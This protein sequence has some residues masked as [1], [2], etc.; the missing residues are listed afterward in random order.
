MVHLHRPWRI[1]LS[2]TAEVRRF[3]T[4]RSYVA[5]AE[6]AVRRCGDAVVDMKYFT[7]EDRPPADVCELMFA[8]CDVYVGVIGF[9]YGSPI[10]DRPGLS[11]SELEFETATAAGL[12]RLVFLLDP[13]RTEG[14]RALFHDDT[15][16]GDRQE[17]FRRRLASSGLL[18]RTVASPA[19]LE[20][21]LVTALSRLHAEHTAAATAARASGA[22]IG[23]AGV[24]APG[25]GT[26]G[27][28]PP[29][30][31]APHRRWVDRPELSEPL[32]AA[33]RRAERGL[34]ALCGPGGFGKTTLAAWL[35]A[36]PDVR[37]R[38]GERVWWVT[39]GQ[40]CTGPELALTVNQLAHSVSG[41]PA[42][43]TDPAQA[44]Q[45]L[46]RAAAGAAGP[47]RPALLVVDDVWGPEQLAPFPTAAYGWTVLVTTRFPD[48]L[49]APTAEVAVDAL[50]D[51][52]AAELLS[53]GLGPDA[54]AHARTLLPALGGWPIV[55]SLVN[56]QL[57]GLLHRGLTVRAA[58]AELTSRPETPPLDHR[59]G[60]ALA[61]TL[62][63]LARR[64]TDWDRRIVELAIFPEDTAVPLGVIAR[65]WAATA[66]LRPSAARAVVAAAADL[67]LV[68]LEPGDEGEAL[69]LHD[70]IRS[71]LAGRG[72][73][74]AA[75]LHRT[76]LRAVRPRVAP[77]GGGLAAGGELGWWDLEWSESYLWSRLTYHLAAAEP[78]SAGPGECRELDAL[79]RDGRWLAARLVRSGPAG[80][81]VDLARSGSPTAR[82]LRR[83]LAAAAHLLGPLEPASA[84]PST[85]LSRLEGDELLAPIAAR[86][87]AGG[88][89]GGIGGLGGLG[90]AAGQASPA[91]RPG[92]GGELRPAW[93]LPD[94]VPALRRT[95]SGDGG[96]LY[97]LAVSPDGKWLAGAGEG[98]SVRIWADVETDETDGIDGIDG[99]DGLEGSGGDGLGGDGA[100][101]TAR[102]AAPG[103]LR[104]LA[105]APDGTWLAGAGD[106]G[107]I[108]LW[109]PADGTALVTMT[110]HTA[111]VRALATAPDG[112]WLAS[113]GDDTTIRLW[114]P[115]DGRALAILTGHTGAVR[116]LATAPDGSWLA[117]AGDDTTIRL[118]NPANGRA[119]AT[120]ENPA[121]ER[122]GRRAVHALV[123]APD[124]SWL[125]SAGDDGAVQLWPLP[126]P[127]PLNSELGT[128][129]GHEVLARSPGRVR[130]LAVAPDGSWLA[131]AGDD[132]TVRLWNTADGGPRAALGQGR[133]VYALAAAPDAGWVASAGGDG[134]LRRWDSAPGEAGGGLAAPTR[135]I[136]AA[137]DGAWLATAGNDRAI[138]LW[139]TADASP[140]AVLAG[141][142]GAPRALA[143]APDGSW[144]ATAGNDRAIRLWNTAD[145]GSRA[146]LTGHIGAPRA[147]VVAPDGS[148]LASA[149]GDGSI[150]LWSG[151]DGSPRPS[152]G[153]RPRRG[154][155]RRG[156][157]ALAVAPDGT[158]LASAG[159]DGAVVLVDPRDG[160][161]RA[162]EAGHDGRVHALV[163]DP[164]GAWL[165]SAGDDGTVRLWD[166]RS[167]AAVSVL[168]GH[169]GAVRALAAASDGCWLAS[170]GDDGTV[171]VWASATGR[172]GPLDGRAVPLAEQ[173]V[174]L[175]GHVGA[176][177]AL[178]ALPDGDRLASAGDDGTLRLWRARD[179]APLAAIRVEGT[180][181]ACLTLSYAGRV[182]LAA[183]G[184]GGVYLFTAP[185]AVPP[186]S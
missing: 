161:A 134:T 102:L 109:N 91:G 74:P 108:G 114:N 98:G 103:A 131:S 39:L 180:L 82:R 149:D 146:V 17:A 166:P 94:Q 130:A 135:T 144:L 172:G 159:E 28:G 60:D 36:H 24:A 59:L 27:G 97:A 76:L 54:P 56:S 163:A 6:D 112:T 137:P 184:S 107:L 122:G 147:L 118:W 3:P 83:R 128:N 66:G 26:A 182:L 37:A 101:V 29:A 85:L 9:R 18:V 105:T 25:L 178:A 111:T 35:C 138:R 125:A 14:P 181:G 162:A 7:A 174:P 32:L 117:S 42:T 183:A 43:F 38:F 175:I 119:L 120:L 170:A 80:L 95:L 8:T 61:E 140:R 79:V 185:R 5:A 50:S 62:P 67:D 152:P 48:L 86:Y 15:G 121:A 46:A 70:E 10:V 4:A 72:P 34:L 151:V 20:T 171:R 153:R 84:L 75:D 49:P 31:P 16:F 89:T 1:F 150:R 142:T 110:G 100:P 12:R 99:I 55:V 113:A 23:A 165:A 123:A 160:S 58:L 106:A 126:L 158:W 143:V 164:G 13:E 176:V 92:Q 90:S 40:E 139:N 133:T 69:R 88:G 93:R 33:L 169:D 173:A 132:G 186:A 77:G 124:G 63:M 104:A 57:R 177:R 116:A 44:G 68:S 156:V 96:R 53:Q 47:E 148:W 167:G 30:P 155:T 45:E 168:G 136:A 179:G 19:E 64:G 154:R 115:S 41:R 21:E 157:L 73:V 11:Y 65:Y 22:G 78:D 129:S 145:G 127:L 52:Q 141:H 2:H 87:R 51:E 81:D 71:A